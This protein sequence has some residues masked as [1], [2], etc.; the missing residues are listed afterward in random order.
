MA[1]RL[2]LGLIDLN[3]RFGIK[4]FNYKAKRYAPKNTEDVKE[5][6]IEHAVAELL[7]A[8]IDGAAQE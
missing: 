3:A 8:V 1:P 7:E 4:T 6:D 5:E 2:Q